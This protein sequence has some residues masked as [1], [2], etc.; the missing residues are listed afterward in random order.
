MS[1]EFSAQ[2]KRTNINFAAFFE[3]HNYFRR[4]PLDGTT[5]GR[6]SSSPIKEH[7]QQLC[8]YNCC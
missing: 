1:A 5:N 8:L 6:V 7:G 4:I 2:T 3:R